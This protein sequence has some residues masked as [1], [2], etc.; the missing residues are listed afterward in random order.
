MSKTSHTAATAAVTSSSVLD[1]AKALAGNITTLVGPP[2][3]LTQ[4]DVQRSTK[5]R[6]G[7]PLPLTTRTA[8]M[9][10]KGTAVDQPGSDT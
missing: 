5:L 3:A 10:K 2:P 9:A 4:V 6:K 8:T 7:R 1:D